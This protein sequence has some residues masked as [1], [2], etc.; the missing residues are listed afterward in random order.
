ML[1]FD[2]AGVMRFRAS[3]GLSDAY[4]AAVEGHSPWT[5]QGVRDNG[6]P[7][8]VLVSDV[9]LALD[10]SGYADVFRAE[11]IRALA[12]VPLVY[13]HEL[14]GK[15]MLYF[16]EPHAFTDD[17]LSV[18]GAVAGQVGASVGAARDADALRHTQE[19]LERKKRI[20]EAV[21]DGL[22]VAIIVRAPDGS[23]ITSNIAARKIAGSP[24]T[25][26]KASGFRA[27]PVDG[28]A[29]GWL[30]ANEWPIVRALRGEHVPEMDTIWERAPGDIRR[31]LLSAFPILDEDGKLSSAVGVFND[32]TEVRQAER[33]REDHARFL[34]QFV[35]IVGHDLRNP[36]SAIQMAAAPLLHSELGERQ[37]RAV[38]RVM[39]S[40]GR[41]ERL[42]RD[43]LDF[44]R[45]RIGAGI[46]V[47]RGPLD[48]HELGR[49]IVDEIVHA[50]DGRR[51]HLTCEGDGH[52]EW[53][54]DRM[55][56]VLSNLLG[57]ALQ[58]SPTDADVS[59]H[60][61]G[62]ADEVVITTTNLGP[63]IPTD[64]L[65]RIFEPFFRGTRTNEEWSGR[66]TR[67]V[68]LGLYIV[69]EIVRAHG[70]RIEVQ[71]RAGAGTSFVVCLPRRVRAEAQPARYR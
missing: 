53:D 3:R 1:L 59:L 42:I 25:D 30:A 41:A 33:E 19:R 58:Y 28:P 16:R 44:A 36:L 12:F 24:K 56:Q 39:S 52:G 63:P 27:R 62:R 7:E 9:H 14:L 37:Y 69:R 71:S 8:P 43:L 51:V 4:R 23:L 60:I 45:A 54:G 2:D 40:S 18:A 47:L 35:G 15:F 55:A 57:N 31:V 34:E 64:L 6:I 26:V 32:V 29:D 48:L 61:D 5:R 11:E 20:V 21:L 65:P 22:P 10:L 50:S 38:Q 46:P 17:E 49:Q 68:G 66:A 67:S 70:G 13:K